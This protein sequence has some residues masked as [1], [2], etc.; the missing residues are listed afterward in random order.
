MG[1]REAFER[2][3]A[4]LVPALEAAYGERLVAVALFGS[5]ARGTM[6][7][8]S[9]VDV[10]LLADP[11][12]EGGFERMREFERA[13]AALAPT[14]AEARGSGVHT[15]IVP[16]IKT[17]AEMRQGSFLHLDL[18]DQAR[19]LYDPRGVLRGYLDDFAAPR[20]QGRRLLLGAQARLQV[21]RS[22]R[23]VTAD[24]LARGYFIRARKRLE[25]L[26]TLMA[27][28]A[29]PDV[30]REAQELVELVLKGML[31][32][33][34]VDPPKWHDVGSILIEEQAK[35]SPQIRERIPELA[36]ISLRL[37]REREIAFYGD[38]DLIPER[39]YDRAAAARALADAERTIEAIG[40]FIG[41][42]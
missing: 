36:E 23:A 28:E 13:E 38:R 15:L 5:V 25:A 17:P 19:I 9:D 37:R 14:L 7:P 26:R 1:Y 10:F 39:L 31:R 34:G 2:I 18:T 12:P 35:F 21:G 11:L 22:H 32:W 6:R 24:E 20:I 42:G 30:V 16:V 8:D 33:V 3:V 41:P 29:Y 4:A 27:V 40:Y